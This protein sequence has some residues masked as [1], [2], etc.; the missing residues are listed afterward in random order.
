MWTR[1]SL[2][3]RAVGD[4]ITIWVNDTEVTRYQD[5]EYKTGLFALQCHNDQ[6]TIEAK[7]LYYRDLGKS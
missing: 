4:D 6:M 7:D 5:R 1:F 2:R 3:V